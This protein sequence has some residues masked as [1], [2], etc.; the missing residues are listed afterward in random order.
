[1]KTKEKIKKLVEEVLL[2]LGLPKTEFTV[3]RPKDEIHGDWASNVAMV[4]WGKL[5]DSLKKKF[6]SPRGLAEKLMERLQQIV[7]DRRRN[8]STEG[9]VPPSQ[10]VAKIKVAG[11]QSFAGSLAAMIDKIEVAG[12]G[13]INFYLSEEYLLTELERVI[14]EGED[15]GKGD[16][17]RR[18][19]V[20][21]EYTDPNPFK[22]FHI[23][24][25]MSNT[26]GES[27]ARL[28]EAGDWEVKRANYQ[29]DV[30][31]HVAKAL[32]GMKKK[33]KKEG[34]SLT[35]IE[36]WSL[37]DRVRWMGQ[38]Y[39]L[40]ATAYKE[41]EATQ[42]EMKQLNR[43]VY[44]KS[45]EVWELYSKGREWSLAYFEKIYERLGT[46]FDEYFFESESAEMGLKVVKEGLEKGVLEESKGAVVFKGEK[47]GLH[48]RVFR[49]S[50]G[51]P[52]YEAKDLGLAL[53]KRERW[54][55]DQSIV[56]TANEVDE[57]FKVVLR[58]LAKLYPD[59]AEKT[60]HISHGVMKLPSGKMSSRTGQVVVGEDLLNDLQAAVL[61]KMREGG[62]EDEAK[63]DVIGVGALKYAVLKQ[64]RKQDIVYDREK[65]LSLEGNSGPYL[66]YAYA[67]GRSVLKK[68]KV[69][70]AKF[71]AIT[72]NLKLDDFEKGV[73]RWLV[74]YTEVVEEAGKGFAP[75]KVAG[76]LYELASRYNKFY[77][78]CRILPEDWE[79][80]GSVL[81]ERT[82]PEE[83]RVRVTITAAVTQVLKNGLRLLGIEVVEE[84]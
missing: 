42:E 39:A 34:V 84:M 33:M 66:Q 79:K 70:S 67:R 59:L 45:E 10:F 4:V 32:W 11:P 77:N 36:E 5:E 80:K 8:A 40:G 62:N 23:G 38:A 78:Q 50:L 63:A 37:E 43:Q 54:E 21:V 74:R 64:D 46:K 48:T 16:W 29:G 25:L 31:M 47:V 72:Q 30:G 68:L 41:D 12:P 28:L 26:V 65:L 57:Y 56:V 7:A 69:Q 9:S 73:I 13:F 71:K 20:F 15:Y 2:D 53:L 14:Q 75:Q 76:F 24:H 17:G 55:Y 19:K 60:K 51:L 18:K 3:E 81:S 61:E 58:V 27:L 35:E 6:G 83:S 82:L 1:M 44:A 49:N 52:T 22:Q